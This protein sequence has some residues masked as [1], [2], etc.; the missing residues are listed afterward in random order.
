M[1]EDMAVETNQEQAQPE[2]K[3]RAGKAKTKQ[4]A[5]TNGAD[6]TK[7]DLTQEDP[8]TLLGYFRQMV[9]LRHF[10]E[11]T[12]EMYTK[13]RIGGYCHLNLGEE[14]TIVGLMA[15]LPPQAYIFTN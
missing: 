1:G 11:R 5:T 4:A 6:T 3:S 8:Q 10:E 2:T 14:A 7:P 13:A 9:L 15:A 12:A